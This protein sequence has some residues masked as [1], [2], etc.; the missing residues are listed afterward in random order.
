MGTPPRDR[1]SSCTH[2]TPHPARTC[3]DASVSL[4]DGRWKTRDGAFT[5]GYRAVGRMTLRRTF[6]SQILRAP[7]SVNAAA[8]AGSPKPVPKGRVAS[9]VVGL[10]PSAQSPSV[11]VNPGN[12]RTAHASAVRNLRFSTHDLALT[13]H[14]FSKGARRALTAIV[15]LKRRK[16]ARHTI[17]FSLLGA[18]LSVISGHYSGTCHCVCRAGG[19]G[20]RPHF[21]YQRPYAK[22]AGRRRYRRKKR[23]CDRYLRE[24]RRCRR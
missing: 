24:G 23:R 11:S 16:A 7:L 4:L 18:A 2:R 14:Y 6:D 1:A 22:D 20:V 3:S 13:A 9:E 5:W 12:A 21:L 17:P 8:S 15:P 19:L 10:G